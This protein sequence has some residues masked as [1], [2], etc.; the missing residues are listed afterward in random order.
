MGSNPIGDSNFFFVPHSWQINI[1]IFINL[2]DVDVAVE[3]TIIMAF[4]AIVLATLPNTLLSE[5]PLYK[6]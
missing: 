1:F 4:I 5:N 6:N 2:L 3:S